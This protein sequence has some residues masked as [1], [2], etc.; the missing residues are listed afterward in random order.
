MCVLEWFSPY[1]YG[2]N[3]EKQSRTAEKSDIK[4]KAICKVVS[5]WF[6]YIKKDKDFF[7]L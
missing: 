5:V 2:I 3:T 7:A 1:K 6:S 4:E